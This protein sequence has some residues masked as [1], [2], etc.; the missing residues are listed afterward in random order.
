MS[1][2]R[3]T[4]LISLISSQVKGKQGSQSDIPCIAAHACGRSACA[5]HSGQ[6]QWLRFPQQP[7]QERLLLLSVTLNRQGMHVRCLSTGEAHASLG[8]GR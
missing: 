4:D 1:K 6:L 2:T 3:K 8:E 7:E 5:S